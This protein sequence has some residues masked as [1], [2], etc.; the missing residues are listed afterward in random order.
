MTPKDKTSSVQ[1][2]R[3]LRQS[4]GQQKIRPAVLKDPAPKAVNKGSAVKH[5][6]DH[7]TKG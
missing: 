4:P 6:K 1:R 2:S 5:G 7:Y 3:K